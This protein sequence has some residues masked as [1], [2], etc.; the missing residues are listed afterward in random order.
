M[1]TY[2]LK[3][4]AFSQSA[5]A[6]VLHASVNCSH[7]KLSKQHLTAHTSIVMRYTAKVLQT[8]T[9]LFKV[10]YCGHWF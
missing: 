1:L 10:H 6:I 9:I 2:Y 3:K 7:A 8:C 5:T 4:L